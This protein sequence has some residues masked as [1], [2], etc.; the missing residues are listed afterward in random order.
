MR[1]ADHDT[2]VCVELSRQM[3]YA[4]CRQRPEQQYI[5]AGG[6][7]SG[8]EGRLEHITR[9]SGVFADHDA[10]AVRCEYLRGGAGQAQREFRRHWVVADPTANA[11]SSEIASGI[12]FRFS[13]YE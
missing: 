2:E 6:H 9:D 12:D 10:T 11:V 7:K 5:H 8:L 4:G 13:R 1:R 3:G